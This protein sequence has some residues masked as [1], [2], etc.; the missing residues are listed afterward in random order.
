[1]RH[2][3]AFNKLLSIS[4]FLPYPK[5]I[6]LDWD[7]TLVKFNESRFLHSF[8]R[9]LTELNYP[10]ST[11][12]TSLRGSK[13]ILDSFEVRLVTKEKTK[14][15]YAKFKEHFSLQ[16]IAHDELMAGAIDLIQVSRSFRIPI[17]VISNLDQAL[18]EKQIRTLGLTNDFDIVLGSAGKPNHSS[19]LKAS[20]YLKLP[21]DKSI[22]FIGDSLQTDVLAAQNAGFTSI[23]VTQQPLLQEALIQA[24]IKLKNLH[25]V[26]QIL[27][28]SIRQ[29]RSK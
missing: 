25:Q 24:D 1:M 27:Q 12:I 21:K 22:W 5:G 19:L 29:G 2:T 16:I 14:E 26:T 10:E 7:G 15:A 28:I 17:G 23:L 18:V 13:S 8:N 9:T 3:F 6:L 20:T 4:R 11:H